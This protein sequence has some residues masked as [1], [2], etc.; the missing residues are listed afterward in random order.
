MNFET[1]RRMLGERPFQPFRVYL[2][3]GRSFEIVHPNRGLA[4]ESIFIIGIP[5]PDDPDPV[6]SDR[7]VWIKW[8]QVDRV[9]PLSQSAKTVS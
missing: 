9:E 5:A 8:A 1:L 4:A 6:V 2:K 3:D 7:Q